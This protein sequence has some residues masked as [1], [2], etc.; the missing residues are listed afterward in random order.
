MNLPK[1]KIGEASTSALG[2]GAMSFA[3]F[4]GPTTEENSYAI[5]DAA[6][7]LGVHHIDTSNVYGMGRSERAIGAWLAANPGVRD[8]LHIATKGGITRDADGKRRFDNSLQHLEAELDQSLARMGI[9]CVDLYYAHRRDAAMPIEE[10]TEALGALVKKGKAKS[11]GFSEIAP[12]SLRRAHAVHPVAAVQSEYSLATR[13]PEL[14]LVQSCAELGVALVAFSPV[15]R[16]LLTDHPLTAEAVARLDFLKVNP[17]FQAPNF[18][19]NL[20]ATDRF[21]ALAAEM[22]VPAAALAIGWVLAQGDHLLPIPGTRSVSHF[23]ELVQG[24]RLELSADDIARIEA[25]LPVGWAH[26]DRYSEAQWVGP[27]RYG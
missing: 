19:A 13:Q 18:A 12:S 8:D 6:M 11:I 10:A 14:G 27:E 20:A 26:G 23:R 1:R 9:D 5:L 7:E 24:A 16:S 3:E 21:R 17:R 22:G 25:V 15:G 2:I 4:Y